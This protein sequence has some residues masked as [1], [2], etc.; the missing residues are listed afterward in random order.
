MLHLQ[1][2]WAWLLILVV[3]FQVK[4]YTKLQL[5]RKLSKIRLSSTRLHNFIPKHLINWEELLNGE[6][7]EAKIAR[8]RLARRYAE[9]DIF[10]KKGFAGNR[11]LLKIEGREDGFDLFSWSSLPYKLYIF[12]ASYLA[13]PFIRN[14]FVIFFGEEDNPGLTNSLE[15]TVIP[16]CSILF[17]QITSFVI[18]DRLTNDNSIKLQINRE[19]SRMTRLS[20]KVLSY[21]ENDQETK[22]KLMQCMWIHMKTLALRSRREELFLMLYQDP[23]YEMK[24]ILNDVPEDG[25]LKMER[26]FE[27]LSQTINSR[28]E[29]LT[30]EGEGT[31][32]V[33]IS[34]LYALCAVTVLAFLEL[35]NNSTI[36]YGIDKS[37]QD[38]RLIFSILSLGF[39]LIFEFI[40]DLNRPFLGKLSMAR[41]TLT[42]IN[43]LQL[44]NLI[45]L[46]MGGD[47][48]DKA[49]EK[50]KKTLDDLYAQKAFN[51]KTFF[52]K[53]EEEAILNKL[54]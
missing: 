8:D 13:F 34:L 18:S 31:P 5:Q 46:E 43:L 48:M 27:N 23:L 40:K 32:Y 14:I 39:N 16:T 29:R 28:Q 6:E 17:G 41:R 7:Y 42:G 10:N 26:I 54:D 20:K 3:S 30:I 37:E 47:W 50:Y 21:F 44:R 19:T 33:Q 53:E 38:V 4:A 11:D 49:E 52:T 51:E 25:S 2:I 45:Y 9:N 15:Y 36:Y 35:S 22:S 1:K 12:G 24:Q